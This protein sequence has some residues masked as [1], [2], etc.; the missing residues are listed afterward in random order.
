MLTWEWWRTECRR[1]E[2]GEEGEGRDGGKE[3]TVLW[4][5]VVVIRVIIHW[6]RYS[7][8][9]EKSMIMWRRR[10]CA[11]DGISCWLYCQPIYASEPYLVRYNVGWNNTRCTLYI[12]SCTKDHSHEDKKVKIY[13]GAFKIS[14]SGQSK[15]NCLIYT[16]YERICSSRSIAPYASANYIELDRKFP[17]LM[18]NHCLNA[19][20]H[21]ICTL[22]I[23]Y[24]KKLTNLWHHGKRLW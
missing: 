19:H 11:C 1:E 15:N 7:C 8:I 2:R 14:F 16:K 3:A 23:W 4:Q 10:R 24:E 13:R 12:L 17:I 6:R 22:Y 20:I 9:L 21:V 18:W 5:L